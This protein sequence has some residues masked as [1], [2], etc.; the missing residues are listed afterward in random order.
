MGLPENRSKEGNLLLKRYL[1]ES[2]R[3]ER[4]EVRAIS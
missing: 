1:I 4:M 2:M 3:S